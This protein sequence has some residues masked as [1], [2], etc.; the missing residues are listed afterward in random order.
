[1]WDKDCRNHTTPQG[2]RRAAAGHL[3]GNRILR[4]LMLLYCQL[5]LA[6]FDGTS[7]ASVADRTANGFPFPSNRRL[8]QDALREAIMSRRQSNGGLDSREGGSI[9]VGCQGMCYEFG[10]WGSWV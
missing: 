7:L 8:S 5:P 9:C 2:G 10:A 4:V 1:M 3:R 6:V